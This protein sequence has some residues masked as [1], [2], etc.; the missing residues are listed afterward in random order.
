MTRFP[1]FECTIHFDVIVIIF[2]VLRNSSILWTAKSR[3][4]PV[5]GILWRVPGDFHLA[6]VKLPKERSFEEVIRTCSMPLKCSIKTIRNPPPNVHVSRIIRLYS[7]LRVF[8][9]PILS[10]REEI[11]LSIVSPNHG[12]INWVKSCWKTQVCQRFGVPDKRVVS[13][14]DPISRANEEDN[15]LILRSLVNSIDSF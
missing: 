2:K 9:P 6:I 5:D 12:C 4:P 15:Q 8:Q 3:E 1:S 7:V 14:E 10:P 11:S 13:W